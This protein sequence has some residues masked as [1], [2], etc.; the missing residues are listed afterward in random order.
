MLQVVLNSE[1]EDKRWADAIENVA[2]VAEKVKE[3][4]FE[5]VAKN[6]DI[7]ILSA[8]KPLIV[9]LCLSD[10]SHVRQLNRDYRNKDK[11][12]NVLT[13]ANLDFA[14]F[15]AENEPFDEIELG[16]II[17]AYETMVR[18]ADEQGVSLRAHFCHLLTHGFLHLSG[19]DHIKTDEAAQ[20]EQM[21]TEILASIGI[22][23]P[24]E[25]F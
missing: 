3:A 10:D 1:I 4:A 8:D 19:F 14:D 9:N 7:D 22:D 5:Y 6:A 23:N 21:E 20:M 18:E 17:V 2:D 25:E 24:Y 12:T 15:N 16:D 11:P 13:F